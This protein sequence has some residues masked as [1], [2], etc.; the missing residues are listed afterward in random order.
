MKAEEEVTT[1]EAAELLNCS[2]RTIRNMII[3][4]SIRAKMVKVDPTTRKG[5]Y[6][7]PKSEIERIK[8]L[9]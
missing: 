9:Q 3:R 8:K 2:P 5:V 1:E 6:K 4:G 7:I